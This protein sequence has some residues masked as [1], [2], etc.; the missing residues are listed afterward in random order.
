MVDLVN[1]TP[2]SICSSLPWLSGA[3]ALLLLSSC[4][5]R[6][7]LTS[8]NS[9]GSSG[10]VE[11]EP[12]K[13][14]HEKSFSAIANYADTTSDA[15]AADLSSAPS[16]NGI[17]SVKIWFL[18]EQGGELR[19]APV[20]RTL[21]SRDPIKEATDQLLRGPSVREQS[22]GIKS[23]I[24]LGTMI[25]GVESKGPITELNLSQK[26]ASGGTSSI[27]ARLSQLENTIKDVAGKSKVF[28]DVEGHRL[29]TAGDGM[30][31]KQPIN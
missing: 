8:E 18:R 23:E 7:V 30:E 31:V 11:N 15:H 25:L 12:A 9:S 5:D 2:K 17:E 14:K 1:Y 13:K 22:E 6:I 28:L 21:R 26:F 16:Q 27:E 3:V 19:P 10:S 20:E 24:P 29:L 4:S